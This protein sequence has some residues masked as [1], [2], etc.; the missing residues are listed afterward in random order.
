MVNPIT[1]RYSRLSTGN[2]FVSTTHS[3]LSRNSV[4]YF[5]LTILIISI[6]ACI[7]GIFLKFST[8]SGFSTPIIIDSNTPKSIT[9]VQLS[10]TPSK[11]PF[12]LQMRDLVFNYTLYN[13]FENITI[14]RL[15][16]LLFKDTTQKFFFDKKIVL[17]RNILPLS[18]FSGTIT[19]HT[20]FPK[21]MMDL[22]EF[23]NVQLTFPPKKEL[24]LPPEK[25]NFKQIHLSI[26][27]R[28]EWFFGEF[29]NKNYGCLVEN[30][31]IL[32]F[33]IAG[34]GKSTMVNSQASAFSSQVHKYAVAKQSTGHVT[35]TLNRYHLHGDCMGKR[36]KRVT[37]IV[38]YDPWGIT[39]DSY[40]T[41]I[42]NAM[43]NGDLPK[44][45]S[46]N[47]KIEKNSEEKSVYHFSDIMNRRMHTVCLLITPE[48][49]LDINSNIIK[50]FKELYDFAFK[51]NYN[52][53]ILLSHLTKEKNQTIL[54]TYKKDAAIYL[55][56][57]PE[58]IH[59]LL[60]NFDDQKNFRVDK[61]QAIILE[62][63]VNRAHDYIE[64]E[65]LRN[66]S[67]REYYKN[68]CKQDG[69]YQNIKNVFT[70]FFMDYNWIKYLYR[71]IQEY[72]VNIV[73][74]GVKEKFEALVKNIYQLF[75]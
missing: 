59:I 43:L 48:S 36:D 19:L 6:L 25:E 26:P 37:S 16:T 2:N 30:I 65:V 27:I 49:L 64:G 40:T 33:G 51:K 41:D 56:V 35:Q 24:T 5:S 53:L 58:E 47:D 31:N 12:N 70:K 14:P 38:F 69:K 11:C 29:L 71:Q 74:L 34:V 61:N 72:I 13:G 21:S 63:L 15:S 55:G 75:T 17:K 62:K 45:F 39:E 3:S 18:T 4:N 32:L 67:L 44:G 1:N 46:M 57:Y 60:A 8:T 73:W 54:E 10:I 68:G 22:P 28:V 52:P 42:L 66:D 9:H 7:I 50:K 23:I 20:R